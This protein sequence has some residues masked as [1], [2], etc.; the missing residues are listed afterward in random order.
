MTVSE[1]SE[2]YELTAGNADKAA[3]AGKSVRQTLS[4]ADRKKAMLLSIVDVW[5]R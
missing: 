4:S 2:L 1:A 5:C 3:I